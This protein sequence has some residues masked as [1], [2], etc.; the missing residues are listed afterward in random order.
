MPSRIILAALVLLLLSGASFQTSDDVSAQSSRPFSLP[1][2]A[3]PGPTT[4]VMV[5]WY[6]N[7]T[8][9]Y[10]QRLNFY[11]MGQGLHFGVDLGARCGTTVVAIGD[12]VVGG[13]DGPW[14]SGPHNLMVDHPN[15]YSSMYGH[16]LERPKL[17]RGQ[18]VK[19]GQP[20]ALSGD[21]DGTC[22]SR[23][24][25]HLEIRDNTYS[26]FYN[27]VNLIE[28]DWDSIALTSSFGRGFERNLDNPRQWQSIYDQPESNGAGPLLNN[29]ARPW[30]PAPNSR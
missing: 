6:G 23:P 16:L 26:H 12:G 9:A 24:H 10:V 18:V 8:F 3:P 19:K 28:A 7:T 14:L 13:G 5:Q 27:P 30:P 11:S 25:L 1:F 17:P 29:F 15:G 22:Y 4:W 21:P 2:T 20:V